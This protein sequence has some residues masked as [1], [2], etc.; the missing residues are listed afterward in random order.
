MRIKKILFS[1]YILRKNHNEF[2][3]YYRFHITVGVL[4]VMSFFDK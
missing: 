2:F 1:H 4:D 3:E